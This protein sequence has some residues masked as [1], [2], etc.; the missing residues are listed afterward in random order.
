MEP[1]I[2]NEE[3]GRASYTVNQKD[4]DA[5]VSLWEFITAKSHRKS[6]V[7][8]VGIMLVQQL[9]GI[10]AIVM[11]GVS[12]LSELIPE[13]GAALINVFI[14]GINLL[15]TFLASRSFDSA[16]RKPFLFASLIGLGLNSLALGT[17]IIYHIPLLSAVA[18]VL[19]VSSFSIGLGPIPWMVAA[20]IVTFDASGAA[21]SIL[22]TTNWIGT[23]IISYGFPVLAATGIGKGGMFLIFAAIAAIGVVF[24]DRFIPETKGV[25]PKQAWRDYEQGIQTKGIFACIG[26]LRDCGP[27]GES[28]RED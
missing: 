22:L 16:G 1:L 21:Q 8:V 28:G 13:R 11:Y 20:E 10:N 12:V 5:K 9:T 27:R 25:D 26:Q 19:F 24:V 7:A 23:F 14:S 2:S 15:F 6:L 17:G 3:E 4:A 18:I